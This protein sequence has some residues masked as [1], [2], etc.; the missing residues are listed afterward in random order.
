MYPFVCLASKKVLRYV[1]ICSEF[2]AESNIFSN[3]PCSFF[4]RTLSHSIAFILPSCASF[5]SL[6]S[7][8]TDALPTP[9]Q[10]VISGEKYFSSL[11]SDAAAGCYH[12]VFAS[13]QSLT[14]FQKLSSLVYEAKPALPSAFSLVP[15]PSVSAASAPRFCVE[16]CRIENNSNM[17]NERTNQPSNRA[18]NERKSY[19]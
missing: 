8:T 10:T 11:F 13:A 2:L 14:I 18:T 6:F 3:F 1:S 16:Q 5:V 12:F 17:P 4:I 15:T 19:V 7:I 9:V